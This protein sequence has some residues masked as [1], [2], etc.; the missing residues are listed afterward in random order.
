M[1]LGEVRRGE[2]G[3]LKVGVEDGGGEI[4]VAEV[5]GGGAGV[6]IGIGIG[7]GIEGRKGSW[8]VAGGSSFWEFGLRLRLRLRLRIKPGCVVDRCFYFL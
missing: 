8:A 3:D 4:G 6:G 7:I 2:A 1:D 5:C